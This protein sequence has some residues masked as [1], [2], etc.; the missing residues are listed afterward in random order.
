MW[1]Y[2]KPDWHARYQIVSKGEVFTIKKT[3]MVAGAKMHQLKS[4]LYI[5]DNRNYVRVYTK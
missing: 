2:D 3:I 4:G 5:T 1:I